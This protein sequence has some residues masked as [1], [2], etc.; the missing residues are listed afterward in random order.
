METHTRI[1]WVVLNL[2]VEEDQG[3][4]VLT[5]VCYYGTQDTIYEYHYTYDQLT[6]TNTIS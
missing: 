1:G 6:I 3:V 2:F 4:M 5:C